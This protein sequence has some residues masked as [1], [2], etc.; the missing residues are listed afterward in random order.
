MLGNG[1][2]SRLIILWSTVQVRAGPPLKQ[3]VRR[4]PSP[5][6]LKFNEDSTGAGICGQ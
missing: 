5:F 1:T 3:G 4:L 2:F 6:F